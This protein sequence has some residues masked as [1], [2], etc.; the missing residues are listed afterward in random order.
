MGL[1]SDA[2]AGSCRGALAFLWSLGFRVKNVI[3]SERSESNG[4]PHA[5]ESHLDLR[6]I[7]SWEDVRYPVSCGFEDG[8]RR[9]TDSLPNNDAREVDRA[10]ESRWGS[11]DCATSEVAPLGMTGGGSASGLVAPVGAGL[12]AFRRLTASLP[13]DARSAWS[14]EEAERAMTMLIGRSAA[15]LGAGRLDPERLGTAIAR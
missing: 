14:A 13:S 8:A 15:C 11:L 5:L 3:L 4:S 6:T 9:E 10:L 7:G 12:L 1:E 2:A